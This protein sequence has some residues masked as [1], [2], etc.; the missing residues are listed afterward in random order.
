M[1]SRLSLLG[2]PFDQSFLLITTLIKIIKI[3]IYACKGVVYRESRKSYIDSRFLQ[4]H[5]RIIY[6]LT[7]VTINLTSKCDFNQLCLAVTIYS[8][9]IYSTI[10]I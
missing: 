3:I 1:H 8:V 5:S 6:Y 10:S 2:I 7:T 4:R 9:T